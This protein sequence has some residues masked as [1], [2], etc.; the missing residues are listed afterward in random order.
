MS[1][2]AKI[3]APPRTNGTC[4][5]QTAILTVGVSPSSRATLRLEVVEELQD[6]VVERPLL[7]GER[8]DVP[9]HQ[10]AERVLDRVERRAAQ[11]GPALERPV[12]GDDPR[13]LGHV[14]GGEAAGGGGLAVGGAEAAAADLV[15]AGGR[16]ARRARR[17]RKTKC[18]HLTRFYRPGETPAHSSGRSLRPCKLRGLPRARQPAW[19]LRFPSAA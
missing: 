7:D 17:F 1:R 13:A 11:A 5:A 14:A 18:L 19:L 16:S 9:A 10:A 15:A 6:G 12:D 3:S 2:S 4:G 8:L